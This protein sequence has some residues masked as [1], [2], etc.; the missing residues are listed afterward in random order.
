MAIPDYE[1]L[2]LPVLRIVGDQ[3]EHAARDIVATVAD[4][5]GLSPEDRQER[6]AGGASRLGNRVAWARVY[7]GKA[8][9]IETVRR[10]VVRITARGLAVLQERP[11]RIDAS[12]LSSTMATPTF[13][14][15]CAASIGQGMMGGAKAHY[16]GIVAFSQ[17]DFTDDLK[18]ITVP[19]LVMHGDDD[20]IVPYADSAP[21]S[22]KLLKNG[23]LKTYKGFPH[24][25]PTTEA[26]TINADLLT[27]VRA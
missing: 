24:G 9:L 27:F 11:P 6:L 17:T 1:T 7:L 20:Q 8:G 22:A 2:M 14:V 23:T 10:G 3:K 5:F 12:F 21:L 18:K 16:D 13:L 4:E 25:M 19:V 15:A 26:D